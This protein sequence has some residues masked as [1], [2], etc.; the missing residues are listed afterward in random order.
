MDGR[1]RGPHHGAMAEPAWRPDSGEGWSPGGPHPIDL[2][3]TVAAVLGCPAVV[4]AGDQL[5]AARADPAA[6]PGAEDAAAAALTD[7]ATWC[8]LPCLTAAGIPLT[9]DIL[10]QVAADFE[11][12]RRP[13]G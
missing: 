7:A 3:Q 10:D 11:A 12:R 2:A 9:R 1:R 6:P 4:A 5:A 13:A 8:L